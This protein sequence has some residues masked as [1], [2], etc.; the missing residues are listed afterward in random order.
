ML[1]VVDAEIEPTSVSRRR[2]APRSSRRSVPRIAILLVA[3]LLI[4]PSRILSAGIQGPCGPVR[5]L[6]NRLRRKR[7]AVI[8]IL[9][10]GLSI[11]SNCCIR[12]PIVGSRR[13]SAQGAVVVHPVVAWAI[14]S[15]SHHTRSWRWC[16]A[17]SL[18]V[19]VESIAILPVWIFWS[20]V[21][22]PRH[23]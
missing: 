11:S 12:K 22:R 20:S 3:V 8:G 1:L 14:S 18:S 4:R 6:A 5:E 15:P 2:R 21:G 17:I 13:S 16:A 9:T 7:S 23:A 19:L 10:L